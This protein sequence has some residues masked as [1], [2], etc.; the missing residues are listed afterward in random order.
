MAPRSD[1][2]ES[3]GAPE[4]VPGNR[5]PLL[6]LGTGKKSEGCGAGSKGRA[7]PVVHF[8]FRLLERSPTPAPPSS[9]EVVA[10]AG[11]RRFEVRGRGERSG[12]GGN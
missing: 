5:K 1:I 7:L 10:S 9:E 11:S 6:E 4:A 2:Q 3:A 8:R 12:V